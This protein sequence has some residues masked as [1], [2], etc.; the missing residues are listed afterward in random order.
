MGISNYFT[1]IVFESV[2]KGWIKG[3]NRYRNP[4]GVYQEA[5]SRAHSGNI[6]IFLEAQC[7]CIRNGRGR[8]QGQ[9]DRT[10]S[11]AWPLNAIRWCLSL[12]LQKML[13]LVQCRAKIRVLIS[14]FGAIWRADG[15]ERR[16]ACCVMRENL[17]QLWTGDRVRYRG[18]KKDATL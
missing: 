3:V 12:I 4:S 17:W 11:P 2:L 14:D 15:G 1:E 10:R 6:G 18:R 13:G 16:R 8:K 9:K 5:K 7:M